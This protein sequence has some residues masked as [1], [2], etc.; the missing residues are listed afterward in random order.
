ME[1]NK[2]YGKNVI[3]RYYIDNIIYLDNINI[4]FFLNDNKISRN[5]FIL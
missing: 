3:N 1:I 4:Y 5:N 2:I